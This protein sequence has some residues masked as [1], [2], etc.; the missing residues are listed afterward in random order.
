M[1]LPYRIAHRNETKQQIITEYVINL[2]FQ[3]SKK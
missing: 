2:I 1:M 3:M